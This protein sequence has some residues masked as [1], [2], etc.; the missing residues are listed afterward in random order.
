MKGLC[1]V[2]DP[3]ELEP[4]PGHFVMCWLYDKS[5]EL[6]AADR[7]KLCAHTCGIPAPFLMVL[8][9]LESSFT[10]SVSAYFWSLTGLVL[11]LYGVS[12]Y[13]N[14]RQRDDK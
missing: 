6:V 14:S 5:N 9:V 7:D 13:T 10:L 8:G 11:T 2:K 1:E 12:D 3:T 4:G